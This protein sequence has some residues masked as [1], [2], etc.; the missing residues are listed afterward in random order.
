MLMCSLCIYDF[1]HLL[2]GLACFAVPE[3]NEDYRRDIFPP[4][5]PFLI[6]LTQV[7]RKPFRTWAGECNGVFSHDSLLKDIAPVS[8]AEE[9]AVFFAIERP[10]TW[11]DRHVDWRGQIS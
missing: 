8:L 1:L 11:R 2:C 10:I 5:I 7:R 4:A 6:P 9:A 3:F